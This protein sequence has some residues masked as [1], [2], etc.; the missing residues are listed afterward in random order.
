VGVLAM[1]YYVTNKRRDRTCEK[2]EGQGKGMEMREDWENLTDGE[3]ERFR[4]V[5]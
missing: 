5:Y 2:A 1:Y 3:N 4:Y